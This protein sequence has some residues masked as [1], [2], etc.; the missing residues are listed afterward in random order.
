MPRSRMERNHKVREVLEQ[1]VTQGEAVALVMDEAHD[2]PGRVLISLKRLWDSA[3]LFKL[4]AVVLVGQG[5]DRIKGDPWGLKQ[6]I[7]CDGHLREF[8]E[9]CLVVSMPA[10]SNGQMKAYLVWR[11][12]QAGGQLNQC[13]ED[14]AVSALARR[15]GCLQLANNLA[16]RA[17]TAACQEGQRQVTAEFVAAV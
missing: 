11:F 12:T 4:L 9:R 13:F 8:A 5:G 7:L 1:A 2:L 6:L 3:M 15:T 14:G 17:M 10:V 16:S